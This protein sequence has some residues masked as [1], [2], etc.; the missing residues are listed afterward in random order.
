MIRM[1]EAGETSRT[2]A[3]EFGISR[4]SVIHKLRRA[5]VTIR[6]QGGRR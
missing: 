6:S 4:Q 2:I 1:Y 3:G 5:G